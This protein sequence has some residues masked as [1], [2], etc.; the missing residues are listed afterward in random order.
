M[1]VSA[2]A[3]LLAKVSPEPNTG[4]WL[5]TG[6][7]DEDGYGRFFY[8]GKNRH[9]HRVSY[10]LH[11]APITDGRFVC[12]TCDVRLCVNPLHLWLGTNADNIRD[13]VR[14]GRILVPSYSPSTTHCFRGH[15]RTA[16]NR[17]AFGRCR[18]CTHLRERSYRRASHME[19]T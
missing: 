7:V 12:H 10:E 4:C 11:A 15:P 9:A 17:T 16:E 8:R 18:P 2:Q 13:G 3:R 19:A 1:R 5:W 6:A 14:K